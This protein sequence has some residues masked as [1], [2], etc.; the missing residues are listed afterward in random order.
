MPPKLESKQR[1]I[2]QEPRYRTSKKTKLIGPEKTPSPG[3]AGGGGEMMKDDQKVQSS[4][5]M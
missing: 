2:K 5:Y 1:I 4:S 3:A